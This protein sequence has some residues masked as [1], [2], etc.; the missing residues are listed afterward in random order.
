MGLICTNALLLLPSC[1]L[2]CLIVNFLWVNID[3]F[4][5]EARVVSALQMNLSASDL[6]FI[7]AGS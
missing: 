3:Y 5:K 6:L 2:W 4:L 7:F 1:S